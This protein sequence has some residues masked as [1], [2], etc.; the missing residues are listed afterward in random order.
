M[1]AT[2]AHDAGLDLDYLV[3]SD[4]V[5]SRIFT[6]AGIFAD[7]INRIFH[8]TWLYAA[9]ESEVAQPGDFKTIMLG[10]TPVIVVRGQDGEVRL[11]VNRCRHRGAQVCEAAQGNTKYFRCWYHGWTY[12]LNGS[13]ASLPGEEAYGGSV[14]AA[15]LGLA[16]VPRVGQYRGF[17][18]ASLAS[19][20]PTLEEH[21]GAARQFIDI[22][23]DYSPTGKVKVKSNV[24]HKTRYRGNWKQVGMDGYHVHYV[25]SSV[26]S[27]LQQRSGSTGSAVGALQ[28]EDPWSDQSRSITRGFPYGHAALDLREQRQSHGQR[29]M[30]EVAR[31]AD[32]KKY[33]ETMVARHGP[34]RAEE[35]IALHGDPHIGIFPNLQLIHDHVRVVVP[36][37]VAET[38]VYMYPIFLE[39][40]PDAF[41]TARLRHH[42]DFYGPASFGSPDD[43][44]LFERTQAGAQAELQ[45][46]ILLGRGIGREVL[47][48][49]QTVTARISDE[50]TQRA[51][52]Q[53]W[54]RLMAAP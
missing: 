48:A 1:S 45:P 3:Q 2:A 14:A 21:L 28:I 27:I 16:A 9:H 51:Q 43:L 31:T 13:L 42:E 15:Q 32:G 25:H 19:T 53:E 47:E 7:E 23:A 38:H 37:S 50:V 12:E 41:N 5:H 8:R 49:D 39:D 33:V 26:V 46:W 17:I 52:M 11:F 22:V 18:F 10:R 34:A 35:I 24:V 40:V 30:A 29:F 44:E 54:K 20:G 4:R 36:I 6:D